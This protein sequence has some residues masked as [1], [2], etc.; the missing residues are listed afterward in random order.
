M[1]FCKNIYPPIYHVY[2]NDVNENPCVYWVFQGFVVFYIYY[3]V[4]ISCKKET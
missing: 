2:E 3:N 1:A 4:V